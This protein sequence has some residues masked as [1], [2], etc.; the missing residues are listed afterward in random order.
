MPLSCFSRNIRNPPKKLKQVGP[1]PRHCGFSDLHEY[2][3]LLAELG[4]ESAHVPDGR[5]LPPVHLASPCGGS[6]DYAVIRDYSSRGVGA[7]PQEEDSYLVKAL[8]SV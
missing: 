2:V 7:T 6:R 5:G 1:S 4:P 8:E 3:T